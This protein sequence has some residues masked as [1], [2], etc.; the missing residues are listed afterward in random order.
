M[1]YMAFSVS[2]LEI[3][4]STG[5]WWLLLLSNQKG[6]KHCP[7]G[8]WNFLLFKVLPSYRKHTENLPLFN[9]VISV[10]S[11]SNVYCLCLPW[12]TPRG[13]SNPP[14]PSSRVILM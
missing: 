1:H 8:P 12:G 10:S 4:L 5:H 2:N 13:P 14:E 11:V 7:H 9:V 6:L 3:S